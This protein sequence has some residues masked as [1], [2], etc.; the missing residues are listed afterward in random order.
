[1]KKSSNSRNIGFYLKGKPK[2]IASLFIALIAVFLVLIF[3][4]STG[5]IGHSQIMPANN[6]GNVIENNN[7]SSQTAEENMTS[8]QSA[9]NHTQNSNVTGT[10]SNSPLIK[11]TAT[12][13]TNNLANATKTQSPIPQVKITSHTKNQIVSEGTLSIHGVSS[14]SPVS[15]CDVYVLLNGIK[16]YQRVTPTEQSG[17]SNGTKDYSLWKFTFLPTYGLI[18]EGDNKMTAKISCMNGSINATKFNSLNV[19]GVSSNSTNSNTLLTQTADPLQS[20]ENV[21]ANNLDPVQG[22]STSLMSTYSP[23]EKCTTTPSCNRGYN[24]TTSNTTN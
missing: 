14:D 13:S 11:T 22:N 4:M 21:T 8:I 17:I 24:T 2:I 1:M 23:P 20:G 10:L 3:E 9:I 12:N 18:T 15:T 5:N 16:P 6:S 19:T 7:L